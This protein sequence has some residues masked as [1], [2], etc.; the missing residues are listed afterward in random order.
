VGPD[1]SHTQASRVN[2]QKST[3]PITK[4]SCEVKMTAHKG[5][6]FARFSP[7]L[8]EN[9]F[10]LFAGFLFYLVSM[11]HKCRRIFLLLMAI[12]LTYFLLLL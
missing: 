12:T 11:V 7:Q 1:Q 2:V 8:G 10:W 9:R 3:L 6:D 5:K 4:R